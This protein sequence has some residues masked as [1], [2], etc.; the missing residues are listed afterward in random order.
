M[1]TVLLIV[2]DQVTKILAVDSGFVIVK[3]RGIAFSLM[4]SINPVIIVVILLVLVK[5]LRK[6]IWTVLILSGGISNLID[7]LR[8]GYVV[9]FIDIKFWPVFNLA[10]LFITIGTFG[11]IYEYYI[12]KR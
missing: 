8:F 7:R 3:N 9:D 5:Y 6:S 10:D 11:V 2:L 12:R 1:K 4:D